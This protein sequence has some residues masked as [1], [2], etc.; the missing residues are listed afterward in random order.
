MPEETKTDKIMNI[1]TKRGFLYPSAEIY[2]AKAGFWTYG[3]L[4]TLLK[5]N[6]ENLWR[7]YFLGLAD[8]YYEIEDC[9][10]MPKEVFKSSGHLEHFND[11]LTECRKC[12]FRFRA[13]QL[14]EDTLKIN[15][16][17]M[18]AEEMDKIIEKEKLKCP[19]CGAQD[20]DNIK[21]FNMMFDIKVG[22]TGSDVM[23]LRP[24]TAQSP[25]LAFK[26]QYQALRERIPFGLAVVGKA[27]RNEISPRQGFFR[28]REF[29]QAELQIFFDPDDVDKAEKWDEVKSYKLKLYLV[30][31]REKKKI[32]EITCEDANKKLKIPKFYLYH[33]AKIQQF[34]MDTLKM[35]KEKFRFR[36]LSEEER[37]FYNKVHFD[38]ELDLETLGGFKEVAGLHYRTDHDLGGHQE[39]SGEKLEVTINGKKFIPHVLELSFGGDRNIWALMDLFFEQE[40]ERTVFRF[41]TNIAPILVGVYPLVNKDGLNE[42]AE[43]IHTMIKKH[44]RTFYDDTGSVGRRYRRMDEIGAPYGITID[45]DTMKDDTVTLRE[46]DSM[47]QIRVG[48]K[49]LK[50]KIDALVKGEIKFEKAGKLIN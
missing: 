47:K 36:E 48:I 30:K 10:I 25:Y 44:Y 13:D 6:W 22:A 5:H 3:H 15:A 28:L 19:K 26:R 27:F 4:G 17:G 50:E 12:H 9:N 7:E 21:W 18:K 38:I 11:P 39:G 42:K 37:A 43:E 46:R 2:G 32:E 31:N 16:D 14:I 20:L 23:Y 41:P 8:N 45:Y 1:A 40:K 35:P 49:E 24:E 34:Y 29:T 33:A